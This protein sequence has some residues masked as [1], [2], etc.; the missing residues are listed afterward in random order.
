MRLKII[1]SRSGGPLIWGRDLKKA[2]AKKGVKAMHKHSLSGIIKGNFPCNEDIIHTT[3]PFIFNLTKKPYILTIHGDFL[4]EKKHISIY[5]KSIAGA[6]AVTVPSEFLKKKLALKNAVVIPNFININEYKRA[7]HRGKKKIKIAKITNFHYQKKAEGVIRLL[8]IIKQA[9]TH[10]EKKGVSISLDIIGDGKFIE[11]AMEIASKECLNQKNLKVKFLKNVSG[12]SK[13]LWNYDI[14]AYYSLLDNFPLAILEAMGSGLPV[15]TN[16]VGAV[17][18]IIKN[19]EFV[20]KND[21]QYCK[22]LKKLILNVK[23][24]KKWAENSLKTVKRFDSDKIVPRFI[25]LYK[26]VLK[27]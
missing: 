1:T 17:N 5:K 22:D 20:E 6:S 9:A 12:A 7:V 8:R 4:K 10:A 19:K 23:E 25:K 27:K 26:K 16:N 2:L 21:N 11:N 3:V 18:E 24:R 13:I 14:F 15:I